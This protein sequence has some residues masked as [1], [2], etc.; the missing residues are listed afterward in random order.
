MGQTPDVFC[1][2]D[3][4][5]KDGKLYYRDKSTSLTNKRCDIRLVDVITETLGKE[6]LCDIGFI[7]LKNGKIT[8]QQAIILNRV[9]RELPSASSIAKADNEIKLQELTERVMKSMEDLITE[10]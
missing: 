2:D 3:F 6:R 7:I 10:F 1:F 8:A 9:E 4:E 5:I